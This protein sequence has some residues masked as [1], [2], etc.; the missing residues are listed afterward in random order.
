[1]TKMLVL[2]DSPTVATGYGRVIRELCWAF[3]DAGLE[4]KVIGRGYNNEPH[5]FPWEIVGHGPNDKFAVEPL[6]QALAEWQPDLLFTLGDIWMLDFVPTL[7]LRD[8]FRWICYFPFDGVPIPLKWYPTIQNVD[9]PIMFSHFAQDLLQPVIPDKEIKFISHGVDTE[10]FHRLPDRDVVRAS[11]NFNNKFVV[12]CVA[13][14]QPRKNLPALVRTFKRFSEGKDNV[15]LY[16]HTTL[17]DIG[18]DIV[19]LLR[20]FDI[21][22]LTFLTSGMNNAS[23]SVPDN[24]L[25]KIY[26]FFD[27]F[28]LPTAGEG[29]GLP[30]LEAQSCEIPVLVTNY[31]ACPELV[32]DPELELIDVKNYIVMNHQ[33]IDQAIVDEDDLLRKLEF[34]YSDWQQGG[35]VAQRL[36]KAGR[37]LAEGLRWEDMKSE[38]VTY[39]NQVI[40]TGVPCKEIKKNYSSFLRV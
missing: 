18:W 32:V 37:T 11:S 30:I 14:N 24:I 33:C 16:I 26:N 39:V 21:V 38:F 19:E 28:V 7:T 4:L 12:G 15:A 20:R 6:K 22:S 5:D 9:Y 34:F 35:Q 27:L 1:M 40:A 13:R 2:A 8:T 3:Y 29:F 10:V 25:N 17:Q 31:S 23:C 36:G